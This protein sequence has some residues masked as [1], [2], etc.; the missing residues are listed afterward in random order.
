M[1]RCNIILCTSIVRPL[2]NK[3]ISALLEH[4]KGLLIEMSQGNLNKQKE[5]EL[6]IDIIMS[7]DSGTL[8]TDINKY[9]APYFNLDKK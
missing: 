3:C 7:I 4:Q 8:E 2:I 6:I 9:I 5:V 1:C